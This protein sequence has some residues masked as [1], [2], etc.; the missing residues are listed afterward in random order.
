MS[1]IGI[2]GGSFNPIH[3]GHTRLARNICKAG[4]VD[5]VWIMVSPL[6]P[7][8]KDE[9]QNILPTDL[10]LEMARLAVERIPSVDV[11]DFETTLAM[12]SYTINTMKALAKQFPQHQF[13]IIIGWDNWKRFNQW[14]KADE[15][16]RLFD[17]VV[18]GRKETQEKKSNGHATVIIHKTS[19]DIID[20]SNS[21]QFPLYDISS[22]QIRNAIKNNNIAF[23]KRWLNPNVLNYITANHLFS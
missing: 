7:L 1:C 16:K 4:A 17:I 18:Y 8:K 14:Y 12:P 9:A 15:I 10:R 21:F 22:T 2:Y 19:R 13:R 6:N 3:I 11:S 20:L 23:A 5:R